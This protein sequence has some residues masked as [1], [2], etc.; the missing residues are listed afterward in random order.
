MAQVPIEDLRR[1]C[2]SVYKLVLLASKRAKEI[3]DGSPVLVESPKRKV[4][5]LALEEIVEGKVSYKE[6]VPEEDSGKR[7]RKA[8]KEERK[9]AT[10]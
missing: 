9:R 1:R 3:A 2:S 8:A 6:G 10:S 4:T 5:S 7:S